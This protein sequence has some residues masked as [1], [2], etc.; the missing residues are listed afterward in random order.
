M[1]KI[2]A[3]SDIA[4]KWAEVTPARLAEFEFGI[5]NPLNDWKTNTMMAA[6][7]YKQA[8]TESI[9][10]GAFPKGV[11]KAGTEKWKKKTTQVIGRWGEG[12]GLAGP[13]FAT[14]F[15]PYQAVI[16]GITLSPRYPKGDPRNYKRV[17]EIG[18]A[19]HKKKIAA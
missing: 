3:I 8:I 6:D 4:R 18:D 7:A 10:R 14:G 15:G 12:V 2:R 1:P 13:D 19:L 9:A 17:Q 5:N 16:A 11:N